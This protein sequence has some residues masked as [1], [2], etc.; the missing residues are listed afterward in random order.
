MALKDLNCMIHYGDGNWVPAQRV[1]VMFFDPVGNSISEPAQCQDMSAE[2][3]LRVM[4]GVKRE[5]DAA[6]ARQ[7]A[8]LQ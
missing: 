3:I 8:E 5:K 6:K 7:K 1:G 2:K 4:D